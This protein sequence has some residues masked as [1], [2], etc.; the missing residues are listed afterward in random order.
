[1]IAFL[2]FRERVEAPLPRAKEWLARENATVMFVVLL[3]LGAVT[4][5]K[6][7]RHRHGL[8][9]ERDIRDHEGISDPPSTRR[10]PGLKSP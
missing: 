8:S 5:G 10:N 6:G 4:L 3:V 7:D 1:M 2:L 9:S